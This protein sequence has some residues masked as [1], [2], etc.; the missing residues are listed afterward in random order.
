MNEAQNHNEI[1]FGIALRAAIFHQGKILLLLR[2]RPS[3]GEYGFWELPG[4]RMNL[5]ECYEDA[6]KREVF[7]ETG[8]KI[9]VLRPLNVFDARRDIDTQV[10][11][12]TFLCVLEGEDMK[13]L[14]SD[15]HLE[16]EWVSFDC[17]GTKKVI[18]GLKKE[19]ALWKIGEQD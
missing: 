10:I 15:E 9:S 16:S 4:G 1:G 19:A 6:V 2:S 14:L 18:P 3:K 12:I 11:G 5:G 17:I 7:E 13:V 8:L